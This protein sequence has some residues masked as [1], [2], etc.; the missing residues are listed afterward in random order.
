MERDALI[1]Y[2][3]SSILKERLLYSSDVADGF[4]CKKCGTF[5]G[6]VEKINSL[7]KRW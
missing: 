2:G 7:I 5:L 1:S 6:A 4:F 3:A